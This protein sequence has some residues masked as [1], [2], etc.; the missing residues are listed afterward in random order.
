[1]KIVEE[2]FMEPINRSPLPSY[3]NEVVQKIPESHSLPRLSPKK[4]KI[5]WGA[6]LQGACL[7]TCP[8]L[9]LCS[10]GY[11][12]AVNQT[13]QHKA[14]QVRSFFH[15]PRPGWVNI[16]IMRTDGRIGKI[17]LKTLERI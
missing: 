3:S 13:C 6:F 8:V 16:L 2:S 5:R 12:N 17:V 10:K 15:G 9:L 1:M 4:R 7:L 14:A 11:S